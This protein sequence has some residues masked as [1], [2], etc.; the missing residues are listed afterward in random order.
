MTRAPC[1]LMHNTVYPRMINCALNASASAWLPTARICV[2]SGRVP[3][4]IRY[5]IVTIGGLRKKA[6]SGPGAKF[7][8]ETGG[9][10]CEGDSAEHLGLVRGSLSESGGSRR[11]NEEHSGNCIT[12]VVDDAIAAH[13]CSF[14]VEF[15]RAVCGSQPR[16]NAPQRLPKKAPPTRRSERSPQSLPGVLRYS[17]A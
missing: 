17:A 11:L 15:E 1:C 14:S 13:E 9:E 10:L 16:P 3:F 5:S 12:P 7:R 8:C 4:G 2:L 6:P